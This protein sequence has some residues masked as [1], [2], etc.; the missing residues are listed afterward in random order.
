MDRIEESVLLATIPAIAPSVGRAILDRFP[1]PGSLLSVHPRQLKALG[2]STEAASAIIDARA[3]GHHRRE[4]DE[5]ANRGLV[6]LTPSCREFPRLLHEI[7]ECPIAI[8]VRGDTEAFSLPAIAIVGARRCTTYGSEVATGMAAELAE[9]G[10][11]VV[12]GLARGIDA[13][14]HTGAVEA[15]GRTIAVLGSGLARI[16]PTE[17]ARLA[18]RIVESGA[19]LSEFPLRTPP[20][21]F[22][23]PRRNRLISGLSFGIVVVEAARR[24]GS[25]STAR[26][27]ADQGRDVFAVPGPVTEETSRGTHH[28][29]RDGAT[30]AEHALDVIENIRPFGETLPEASRRIRTRG[31]DS[32]TGEPPASADEQ[33]T[34]SRYHEDS[35]G[36][37]VLG[38]L[39]RRGV[40]FDE[41]VERAE[42]GV[43]ATAAVLT[44][45]EILGKVRQ[46]G[47]KW[48]YRKPTS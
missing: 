43:A 15:S 26:W 7:Q 16:Y 37:R 25:L 23:F 48:F 41:I 40:H 39:T 35:P 46:R 10:V 34:T 27:A 31:R 5:A 14:A 47:G 2:V 13:A 6:I 24:S 12:S 22:H 4:I 28:L 18:D 20:L 17:N 38:I 36:G 32:G 9:Q 11:A 8:W 19:V 45:L 33:E 29:L 1:E 21:K 30:I 42:L 44:E 3:R